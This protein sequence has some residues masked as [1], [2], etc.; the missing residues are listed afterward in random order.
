MRVGRALVARLFVATAVVGA[1][2]APWPW[3]LATPV[4]GALV[5]G[6]V[7]A[8]DPG[9]PGEVAS[10][11]TVLRAAGA[12]VLAVPFA[13]ALPA[14]GALGGAIAAVLL[15]VGSLVMADRLTVEESGA[16]VVDVAGMGTVLGVLPT[17]ELVREWRASEALL[18]SSRHRGQAAELRG[19]LLDELARRDPAGVARWLS[20]GGA[21]P[22][23]YIRTDRDLTG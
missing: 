8:V 10:R 12:A 18:R 13:A 14:L 11:R 22:D 5:G 20:A 16:D 7:A 19:L 3:M 1:V 21:S 2:F 4:L 23:P 6:L 9:F 15:F 17:R